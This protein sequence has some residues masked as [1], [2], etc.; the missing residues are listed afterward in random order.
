MAFSLLR[1]LGRG[2]CL[3]TGLALV[4]VRTADSFTIAGVDVRVEAPD[5][6]LT[7]ELVPIR[8]VATN[9]SATTVTTVL[10]ID[11]GALSRPA[12]DVIVSD[13]RGHRVWHRRKLPPPIPGVV[14]VFPPGAKIVDLAP[15][16]S[17]EWWAVWDQRDDAGVPVAEGEYFLSAVIP[18]DFGMRMASERRQLTILRIN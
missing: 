17:V 9:H 11:G 15:G 12:F 4:S 6:V 18:D 5:T 7:G 10:R 14:A 2:T 16:Q 1:R 13:T 8:V 3:V